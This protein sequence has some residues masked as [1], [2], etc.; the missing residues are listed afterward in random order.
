[1]ATENEV[2]DQAQHGAFLQALAAEFSML[3]GARGA[4]ISESSSRSSLYM[5]TLSGAV[6]A[7]ALVAQA[8]HFGE[9]FFIFALAIMPV[10][11]FLGIATY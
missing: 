4:T 7:L 10:V 3:Q 11:F 5:T 2:R 6:V 9:T 8:A 1:M